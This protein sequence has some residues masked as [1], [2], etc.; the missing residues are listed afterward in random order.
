MKSI[1][2]HTDIH[3]NASGRLDY[4]RQMAGQFKA[5][6]TVAYVMPTLVPLMNDFYG[7]V[8][9]GDMLSRLIEIEREEE[10]TQHSMAKKALLDLGSTW[11]WQASYGDTAQ[12]LVNHSKLADVLVL[13]PMSPE[14]SLGSAPTPVAATVALHGSAPV[15]IVPS[16]A[17]T[18]DLSAPVVIAWNGSVEAANAIKS[19]MQILRCA[20][21]VLVVEVNEPKNASSVDLDVGKYLAHH[22]IRVTMVAQEP[23]G[24]VAETLNSKAREIG[25]HLIVAGAYG[26]PRLVEFVFGGVSKSFFANPEVP[27]LMCH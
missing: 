5:H 25:A 18:F 24:S 14:K 27:V 3:P 26:R 12:A 4:A 19:A 22:G 1:T 17:P 11:D 2:V 7:G 20:A 23:R 21:Q 15:I 8:T 6:L 10:E 9:T 16:G 13:G